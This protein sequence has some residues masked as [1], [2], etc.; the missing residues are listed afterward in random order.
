M[1]VMAGQ[2]FWSSSQ[3]NDGDGDG[4]GDV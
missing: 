3:G 2:V 4:G 1:G